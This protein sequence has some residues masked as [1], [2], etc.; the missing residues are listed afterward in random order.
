MC[1]IPA[2]RVKLNYISDQM[3]KSQSRFSRAC[4]TDR[5]RSEKNSSDEKLHNC[6][7][8][9]TVFRQPCKVNILSHKQLITVN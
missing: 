5:V 7:K 8:T 1:N 4:V 3:F 9:D 6:R 2:F